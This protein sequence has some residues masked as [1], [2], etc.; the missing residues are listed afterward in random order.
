MGTPLLP[1][2]Q[3]NFVNGKNKVNLRV[4]GATRNPPKIRVNF[5]KS[6]TFILLLL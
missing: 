5:T 3:S 1:L 2:L 4:I 6:S